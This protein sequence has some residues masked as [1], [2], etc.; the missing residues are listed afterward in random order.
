[1]MRPLTTTHENR[2]AT[3][4]VVCSAM[5]IITFLCWQPAYGAVSQQERTA[6]LD[7]YSNVGGSY[8]TVSTNWAGGTGTECTWFG[9]TCDSAQATV[10]GIA[11]TNNNVVGT[12]PDS[13]S[14]LTNLQQL[15]LANNALTGA[16]PPLLGSLANLVEVD[17]SNNQLTGS[18]P[19]F[20]GSRSSLKTLKLARNQLSGAI[21]ALLG[22]LT[23]LQRLNL[24]TNLLSDAI[25]PDLGNLADLQELSLASNRLTGTI[26]AELGRLNGLVFLNLASNRLT[27]SIPVA[28]GALTKLQ[29]VFLWSNRLTGAIP[30]EMGNLAAVEQL[31][32]SSNQLSG[33]IPSSLGSLKN[34]LYLDLSSNDLS[35]SIPSSLGSLP[36]LSVLVLSNNRLDG[37]IPSALGNLSN[38]YLLDLSAN[39][40][41]GVIPSSLGGLEFLWNLGLGYNALTTDDGAFRSFLDSLQPGWADTQTI[42]PKDVTATLALDDSVTLSWSPVPYAADSGRYEVWSGTSSGGPY[43]ISAT[44]FNKS[45]S[46]FTFSNLAPG[47]HYFVVKTTTHPNARNKNSVSSGPSAEIALHVGPKSSLT[48][49][50][51]AGGAATAGTLGGNG[52]TQA[53]YATIEVNGGAAPYA[54]AVLS[55]TKNGII[56]GEV[57]VPASA[58]TT[59]ALVFIDHRSG[60]AIPGSSG[61]VDISTGFAAVN[62]GTGAAAVTA[63]L[64]DLSGRVLTTGTGTIAQGAHVAKYFSQLGDV[65]AGFSVPPSFSVSTMFGTL[66]LSSNQP[67]SVVALRLTTNQR[68]DTLLTTTPVADRNAQPTG[69]RM[70][71]PQFVNGGGYATAVLLINRSTSVETGTLE[72]FSNDGSPL[73]AGQAGGAS[74]AS[75]SYSIP[76]LGGYVF[77][78]DALPADSSL[79]WVRVTPTGGSSTPAGAGIVQYSQKGI[80]TTETGIA[81]AV[82]TTHA[83]IFVDTASGHDTGLALGNPGDTIQSVT[84]TAYRPD[85]STA[86]GSSEGPI[87]L[88]SNGHFAGFVDQQIEGLPGGFRGVLDIRSDLPFVA[89]TLRSLVNERDDFLLTTFPVADVNAPA[90]S[91]IVIP[92][93]ADGGGFTTE[94]ILLNGSTAGNATITF[95]GDSGAPIALNL[96]R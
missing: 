93:F 26:P 73:I 56:T 84:L 96:N 27:G 25:P 40:L 83:R 31:I 3:I 49:G 51:T 30:A 54:T 89:L 6:L 57:G 75:F 8:W 65:F 43:S 38:L 37:P 86:I 66:E 60:V 2:A 74:S 45:T 78:T 53:G 5:A 15:N 36:A 42:P 55:Y 20:F 94:F 52:G 91:P 1:M 22:S 18:I 59:S 68:G 85:G 69:T 67:L 63:V 64:R 34:L 80:L 87:I 28:L 62:T 19:S 13:I 9:V 21:P 47:D 35:G 61:K 29:S 81:S 95:H 23:K 46:S 12:I 32:L 44:T 7:I 70:Y 58:P 17:L 71:L 76:P 14:K 41:N 79:G 16:I 39:K 11:L 50:V 88:V 10:V 92:Q 48:L 72:L 82:P 90:P 24:A 4:R 77:Q 33:P